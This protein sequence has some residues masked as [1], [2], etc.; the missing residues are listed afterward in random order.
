MNGKRFLFLV[1]VFITQLVKGQE[2]IPLY[3]GAVPGNLNIAENEIF[4][5][6]QTAGLLLASKKYGL[7]Q[8]VRC[9]AGCKRKDA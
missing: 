8:R 2:I 1:L 6:P 5:R 7:Y 4:S 3:Q 9:H